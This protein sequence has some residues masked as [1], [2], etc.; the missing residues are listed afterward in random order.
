MQVLTY[1]SRRP[2][3]MEGWVA[4][5]RRGP[6]NWPKVDSSNVFVLE[7]VHIVGRA[8]F[9]DDWN[10]SELN[11]LKWPLP[12]LRAYQDIDMAAHLEAAKL[13]KYRPLPPVN[14]DGRSGRKSESE[15]EFAERRARTIEAIRQQQVQI[16]KHVLDEQR[17]WETNNDALI[18]LRSVADWLGQRGRDG[19]INGHYRMSGGQE[20][21]VMRATDWNCPDEFTGWLECGGRTMYFST[22]NKTF[23]CDFF[24]ERT[25]L[26]NAIATLAHAPL[27]VD[28]ADL[29]RLAPDLQLA[30]R[31][32]L[33]EKLFGP[34][35]HPDGMVQDKII[36]A[37]KDAGWE[38]KSTKAKQMS[39]TMRWPNSPIKALDNKK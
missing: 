9:G 1:R 26:Q 24:L 27:M 16:P 30:V 18:R 2:S 39:A 12:P 33:Q 31:I 14:L 8:K 5:G 7:A 22:A 20:P 17:D 36:A 21:I 11:V 34:G 3:I 13:E 23:D 38:I 19:E 37:A 29:S 4:L 32:A 35:V 6:N 25:S 10:G 28:R 15:A